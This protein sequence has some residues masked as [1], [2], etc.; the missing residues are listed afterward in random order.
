MRRLGGALIWMG[1]APLATQLWLLWDT[2]RWSAFPIGDAWAALGGDRP[3]F[4]WRWLDEAAAALLG[5]EAA[6][7]V[8]ALG[9]TIVLVPLLRRM[10]R[11]VAAMRGKGKEGEWRRI[12]FR[13]AS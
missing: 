2:G 4:G 3:Y 12:D 8:L 11:R 1:L 13:S 9:G 6:G 7:A 5:V 10:T